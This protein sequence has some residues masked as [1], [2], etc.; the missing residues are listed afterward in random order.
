MGE[1]SIDFSCIAMLIKI[2][3]ADEAEYG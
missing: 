1:N 2:L 3:A